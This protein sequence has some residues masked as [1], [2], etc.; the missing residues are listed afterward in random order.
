MT[1]DPGVGKNPGYL[2]TDDGTGGVPATTTG[3]GPCWYAP[4]AAGGVP[5][6]EGLLVAAGV[7]G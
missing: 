6:W 7:G 5:L 4:P 2:Q 3:G 1:H